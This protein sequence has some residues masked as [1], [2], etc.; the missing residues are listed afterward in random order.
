MELLSAMR[1]LG[2]VLSVVFAP[3]SALQAE[4]VSG[5]ALYLERIAAPPKARFVAVLEDIS[6]ADAPAEQLGRVVRESAGNPPYSFEIAYDPGAIDPSHT[7]A[8]RASLY[9]SGGELLFTTDTVAPVLT[10][11][12]PRPA[13]RETT[14]STARMSSGPAPRG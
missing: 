8:V 5:T 7:Y 2:F 10:R 1:L 6:R 9:S 14:T 12:P 3:V 4:T 11:E 13:S